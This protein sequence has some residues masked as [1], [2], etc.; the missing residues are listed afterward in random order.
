MGKNSG[1]AVEKAGSLEKGLA[2]SMI[3]GCGAKA[4]SALLQ[5]HLSKV[6]PCSSDFGH[7]VNF[8]NVGPFGC[9][10]DREAS[11][12]Q[13]ERPQHRDHIHAHISSPDWLVDLHKPMEQQQEY[14][15]AKAAAPLEGQPA[16]LC[17]QPWHDQERILVLASSYAEAGGYAM[18][19]AAAQS[20]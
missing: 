5:T 2:R 17:G 6:N 12:V 15:L 10:L 14:C 20:R 16:S 8:L 1:L 13:D 18:T 19:F 4:P 7:C 9:S 11:I 3:Y